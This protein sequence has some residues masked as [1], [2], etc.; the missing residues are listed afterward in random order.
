VRRGDVVYVELPYPAER[1]SREQA[2]RRPAIAVLSATSPV[3]NPMV[4]VVPITS[5]LSALRF[6][7]VIQVQPSKENGLTETS[8][9]L[10]F[11]L[12]ALDKNRLR[13][14][15]GHLEDEHITK[16]DIELRRLLGL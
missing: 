15:M 12:R 1:G 2:G 13:N 3:R 9:L 7:H 16:L 5:Q 11:Q 6:P 14:V 8:I 10:V 4:M